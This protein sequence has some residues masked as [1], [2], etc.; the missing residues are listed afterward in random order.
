MS[1]RAPLLQVRVE[2]VEGGRWRGA[3]VGHRVS[4]H[5]KSWWHKGRVSC[6]L[7]MSF[8]ALVVSRQWKRSKPMNRLG[9]CSASGRHVRGAPRRRSRG[10]RIRGQSRILRGMGCPASSEVSIPPR[11]SLTRACYLS[12]GNPSG[13]YQVGPPLPKETAARFLRAP[14]SRFFAGPA[15]WWKKR[16]PQRPRYR[17]AGRPCV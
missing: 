13:A 7:G 9:P 15:G 16:L 2:F 6:T 17:C 14:D 10:R 5:H 12:P 11:L 1:L 3:L 4:A 8:N